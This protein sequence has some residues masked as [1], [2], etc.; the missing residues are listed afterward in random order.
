MS[1]YF[2]YFI[3]ASVPCQSTVSVEKIPRPI[4]PFLF[5]TEPNYLLKFY[6]IDLGFSETKENYM[7]MLSK[8]HLDYKLFLSFANTV[9]IIAAS[10]IVDWCEAFELL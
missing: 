6:Y 5:A 8:D 7:L 4:G 1:N 9:A 3:R 10:E 2:R